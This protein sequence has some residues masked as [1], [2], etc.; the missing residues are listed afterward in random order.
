VDL[1][2]RRGALQKRI[3][4]AEK[5]HALQRVGELRD[6]VGQLDQRIAEAQAEFV[7]KERAVAY[8]VTFEHQQSVAR[9]L[10]QYP[11][12]LL[13]RLCMPEADRFKGRAIRVTP[14]HE[15]SNIQFLNLRYDTCSRAVR[16]VLTALLY[17]LLCELSAARRAAR[18]HRPVARCS[19]MRWRRAVL[20]SF[21][22]VFTR[23]VVWL[24]GGA[25][26]AS[27]ESLS[28]CAASTTR[29]RS[30]RSRVAQLP[31]ARRPWRT[32]RSLTATAATWARRKPST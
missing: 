24:S 4:L 15:P 19:H 17:M 12:S 28:V 6:E 9:C 27:G 7:Q 3:A 26:G 30:A 8:F 20:V 13:R 10:T 2:I 32:R 5:R 18:V 25:P 22:V 14:A 31:R 21:T 1:F 16:R 29:T 11:N 23:C